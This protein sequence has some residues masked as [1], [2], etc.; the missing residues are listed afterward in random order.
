MKLATLCYVRRANQTLMIH[1]IKK[2][3]DMHAGKWNG[4]GGKFEAGESPEECV[5]REVL[6]ESGLHIHHPK[7]HGFL[8]FPG[9]ANDE[10]WYAFVF[11]AREFEGELRESGEGVLQWIE[12]DQLL[13]LSL[14]EGDR[15]F[16]PLL[17][18][19]RMFS[20]KFIYKDGHL[21][22]YELV[23]YDS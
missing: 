4:L 3:N 7:L 13:S 20:G 22:S 21:E 1:R 9:F 18:D 14:W 5:C 6:E 11:S 12:N 19:D 23:L 16:L 17:A 8:T 10:D 15:I 2:E